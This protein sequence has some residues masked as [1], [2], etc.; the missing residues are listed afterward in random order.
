MESRAAIGGDGIGARQNIDTLAVQMRLVGPQPFG[1]QNA[2]PRTLHDFRVKTH[3][4][5]AIAD[6]HDVA[7][8]YTVAGGVLGT[9]HHFR[10][11]FLLHGGFR[12]REGGVE[13]VARWRCRQSERMLSVGGFD[14]IYLIREF[15]KLRNR[16]HHADVFRRFVWRRPCRPFGAETEFSVTITKALEIMRH[17]ERGLRIDP[18]FFRQRIEIAPAADFQHMIDMVAG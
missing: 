18:F 9:D 12:F 6:T 11:A 16:P 7:I 10:T 8:G 5:A 1:N 4:A 3:F 2:G 17:L 13:E 15:R 14:D